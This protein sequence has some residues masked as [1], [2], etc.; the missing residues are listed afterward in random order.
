MLYVIQFTGLFL[1][2]TTNVNMFGR[3]QHIQLPIISTLNDQL[4]EA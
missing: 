2:E 3:R 4:L 1:G